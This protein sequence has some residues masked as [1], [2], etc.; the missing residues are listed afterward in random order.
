MTFFSNLVGNE[1]FIVGGTDDT[2]LAHC[3]KGLDT[4]M[5]VNI[6]F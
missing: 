2:P 1:N 6:T 5:I 3:K 4:F